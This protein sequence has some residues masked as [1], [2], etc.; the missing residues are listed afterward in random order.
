MGTISVPSQASVELGENLRLRQANP[1]EVDAVVNFNTRVFDERISSWTRDLMSGGH[2]T[3]QA[4]DFT[5]VEDTRTNEIVS[6]L[7]VI[8][9]TWTYDGVPF[10]VGRPELVATNP[11]YRRRGLVR[12]QFDFIHARG[13]ANGELMQVIT[14]VDWFYRQFGYEMGIK[15]WGS[16]WVESPQLCRIEEAEAGGYRLRAAQAN[17]YGF[18]SET[19]EHATQSQLFS[20]V[21]SPAEWTYEFEGRSKSNTRRR[22]W[23]VIEGASA[24]R[25]GYVQYL[26]CLASAS[27]PRLRIY[28]IELKKG[29]GYLNLYPALLRGL[30]TKAKAL[31]ASGDLQCKELQGIEFTMERD[32]P[33]FRV[34]PEHWVRQIKPSPYYLRLPD[35][36]AFLRQVR[37]ALERHLTGTV[38]EGYSGELKLNFCRGGLR[39]QFDRGQITAIEKWSPQELS[40]GDARFPD[41]TFSH[42]VFGWRQTHELMNNFPDCFAKEHAGVLLDCLFP[43]FHG[44]VWVL[45]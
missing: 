25:L 7:C 14:G 4:K 34:L 43:Q 21:R 9:Q 6:S 2:P 18:I 38:A 36:V 3:V 35:P 44:K 39:I 41:S 20:A 8:P 27:V 32:H 42:L 10:P 16:R 30:W 12:K 28:Q 26:P 22:E 23:L 33:L 1:G 31:W 24:E 37:S 15:L 13:A 17:D 40:E 45:A 19:Y 11:E 5:V 29:A